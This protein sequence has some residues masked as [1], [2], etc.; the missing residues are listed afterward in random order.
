MPPVRPRGMAGM[1]PF[2]H[3]SS[4]VQTPVGREIG[5]EAERRGWIAEVR[6]FVTVFRGV[7][8]NVTVRRSTTQ[9]CENAQSFSQAASPRCPPLR[10]SASPLRRF[11]ASPPRRAVRAVRAVRAECSPWNDCRKTSPRLTK[12]ANLRFTT[13]FSCPRLNPRLF[14]PCRRDWR[15][16]NSQTPPLQ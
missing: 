13:V 6:H 3:C 11:A 5:G 12:C 7:R 4:T 14:S 9:P 2:E 10:L 8:Q 16:L 15:R 1:P